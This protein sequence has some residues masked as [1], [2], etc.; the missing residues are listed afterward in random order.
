[1]KHF[2]AFLFC[3]LAL[4]LAA[5]TYNYAGQSLLP[6][7]MYEA[8]LSLPSL[9][10]EQEDLASR[11]F[12]LSPQQQQI[13]S[14]YEQ[15]LKGLIMVEVGFPSCKPCRMLVGE[16]NKADASGF[17][18]LQ[19]WASK[20]GRFYQLDWT[21]DSRSRG[22]ENLS[23]LWQVQSVPVLLFFKDGQLQARLNGFNAQNPESSLDKIKAWIQS[24]GQ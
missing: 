3:V 11:G 9:R 23:A 5:Q 10:Q 16:M 17:S 2:L 7:D 21:K 15:C 20:G 19:Q 1:M 6:A 8:F 12:E 24:A 4:P 22:G 13:L 14:D 18:L